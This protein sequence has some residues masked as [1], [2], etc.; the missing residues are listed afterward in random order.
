MRAAASLLLSMALRWLVSMTA[1][2]SCAETTARLVDV[3]T[4]PANI[5]AHGQNA[6]V[7]A[8]QHRHHSIGVGA[9]EDQRRARHTF[10]A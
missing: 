8:G 1:S 4:R 9:G 5:G 3:C 6:V 7:L 2:P 10:D